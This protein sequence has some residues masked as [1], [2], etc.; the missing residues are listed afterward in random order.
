MRQMNP[1]INISAQIE[2]AV[3]RCMAKD[4]D[5]RFRSMDEVLAALKRIGAVGALTGTVSGMGTGEYRSLSGSGSGPQVPTNGLS[6]TGPSFLSPSVSEVPSPL[7]TGDSA[8]AGALLVSQAP[9][10]VG[11]KG[12]LVVAVVGALGCAGLVAYLAMRPRLPAPAATAPLGQQVAQPGTA[13]AP[14]TATE[15][16]VFAAAPSSVLVKVRINTEPD[17]ASV[18]EDGVELCSS[19]P[20]DILYKGP[21]AD[22]A[23][24]HRLTFLHAGYRPEARNVRVGDSPVNIKLAALP[25]APRYVAP[26]APAPAR[27]DHGEGKSESPT[28]PPGYKSDVPY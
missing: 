19:T 3:A 12:T 11:S 7:R 1:A 15:G 27:N 14:G 23:K 25:A 6:G 24:E 4:P 13:A 2:D 20:C 26:Q 22:A 28:L 8:A 10:R 18:K 17:G 16:P 21:D 9:G 5:Q